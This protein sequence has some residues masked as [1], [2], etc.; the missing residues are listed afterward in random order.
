MGRMS[1]SL[2]PEVY[3]P[4]RPTTSG[5]AVASLITG[6]VLCIPWL[7]G[8][9]AVILGALGLSATRGG[10]RAGRGMAVAGLALGLLNVV[11]WTVITPLAWSS[12]RELIERTQPAR[13]LVN[14]VAAD[15]SAGNI[16]AAHGK[17]SGVDS[18]QLRVMHE[19]MK[20]WGALQ[21]LNFTSINV[22]VTNGVQV[23]V[24]GGSATFANVQKQFEATLQ[25][26]LPNLKVIG[27]SFDD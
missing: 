6:L 27:L 16:D 3:L 1:N 14:Q 12:I 22:R 19:K 18:G 2:H 24:L 9:A 25:G 8:V 20:P 5:A 21:T 11:A 4:P 23:W 10:Q 13:D 7:T 17:F 15:I 26:D